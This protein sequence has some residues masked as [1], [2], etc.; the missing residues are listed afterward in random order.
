[1]QDESR[2]AI[3]APGVDGGIG[4]GT[5]YR[6]VISTSEP[7][8]RTYASCST[9][10]S[11]RVTK[12]VRIRPGQEMSWQIKVVWTRGNRLAAGVKV[13]LDART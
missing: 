1:M 8:V 12:T 6:V 4:R 5:G 10:T 2:Q 11:C 9:G 3:L 13:C 7:A